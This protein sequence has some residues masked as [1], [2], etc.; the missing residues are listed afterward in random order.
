[1]ALASHHLD[2]LDQMSINLSDNDNSQSNSNTRSGSERSNSLGID[3]SLSDSNQTGNTR[4]KAE[5]EI[6]ADKVSKQVF[7]LKITVL[8]V[9]L[10]ATILVSVA[11]YNPPNGSADCPAD[12]Q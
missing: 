5:A 7:W 10:A 2:R 11:I 3:S 1:M 8:L 4:E 6:L 12:I 9:L